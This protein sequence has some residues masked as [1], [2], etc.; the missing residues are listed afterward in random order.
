[1]GQFSS[2]EWCLHT[3][4]LW[5]GCFEVHAGCDH[6]YARTL[7]KSK[8]KATAWEGSRFA[9]LSIWDKLLKWQKA[10][11]KAGEIHRVFTGS[12]MDIFEKSLP[13]L[14]WHGND[15]GLTTGEMRDRYFR[16]VIPA[17]PNLLHLLLTKR[18]GNVLGMV[19]SEWLTDWP[20]NVMTGA[21]VVNQETAV[22]LVP[23]LLRVPGPHFLSVEPLLGSLGGLLDVDGSVA[24]RMSELNP[25]ES[26]FPADAIDWVIVG[27]ES[28]HGARPM[29]PQWARDL[30][31][32]CVS[33]G[34]PFHFK[35]HGEWIADGQGMPFLKDVIGARN[36]HEARQL[37]SSVI[38]RRVGKKA[39]GRMLDG[40]T[41]DELPQ[42]AGATS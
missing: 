37:D 30:R 31:D 2:I 18:P 41:W 1:M 34:V 21:S 35:Q 23:Q 11:A 8:G 4:N 14:D 6:C 13:V 28:G 24:V 15:I 7:A 5:W 27:G 17:T 9:V 12:M 20:S 19:P 33:A 10:A 22:T 29:D 26:R 42:L 25:R 3:C 36:A 16:E 32:Q 38:V 40:R 39:A